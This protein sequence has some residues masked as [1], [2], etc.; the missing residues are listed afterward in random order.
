MNPVV[1]EEYVEANGISTVT[2]MVQVP[3]VKTGRNIEETHIM[4]TQYDLQTNALHSEAAFTHGL[5]ELLQLPP[6][7]V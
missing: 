7:G 5:M 1:L 4:T 2:N 6:H 3:T